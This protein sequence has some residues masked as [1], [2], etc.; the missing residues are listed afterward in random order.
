MATQLTVLNKTGPANTYANSGRPIIP[1]CDEKWSKA[2]QCFTYYYVVRR[3]EVARGCP[4]KSQPLGPYDAAL[5]TAPNLNGVR[6]AW[7][8]G[9][10]LK[11]KADVMIFGSWGWLVREF[12]ECRTFKDQDPPQRKN[13][14]WHLRLVGKTPLADGT[15]IKDAQ[16]NRLTAKVAEKIYAALL[17]T[18]KKNPLTGEMEPANRQTTAVRAIKYA[19]RAW[20][21]VRRLEPKFVPEINPFANMRLK[22]DWEESPAASFDEL[23][24]FLA[25]A[26][27]LK[28]FC[29]GAAALV[30]WEWC[31][32]VTHAFADFNVADFR[33]EGASEWSYIRHPKVSRSNVWM[34]LVSAG[35]EP[36]FDELTS[37][38][39]L[40]KRD[41]QAGLMLYR[42]AWYRKTGEFKPWISEGG[43][44][45]QM[46]TKV[47]E[48]FEEARIQRRLTLKAFRQGGISELAEARLSDRQIV[49]ITRQKSAAILERYSK[50]TSHLITSAI[51]QRLDSRRERP[52][53]PDPLLNFIG[54]TVALPGPI[55]HNQ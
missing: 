48:I 40:I 6:V 4:V 46:R 7:E 55:V 12:E 29:I 28:E 13:R 47:A 11:P 37:R 23:L 15:T 18:L 2:K 3:S 44:L 16:L 5:T 22:D 45:T 41:R 53:I 51:L 19:R 1:N 52:A 20:N 24:A 21:E 49:N 34:P 27:R 54:G 8:T 10:A 50:R 35:G 43:D 17:P 14:L 32:R 36:L 38:L 31:Q 33:P 30:G 25:A 9:E 39:I 26:D 42:D